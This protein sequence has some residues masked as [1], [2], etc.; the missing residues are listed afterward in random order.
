MNEELTKLNIRKLKT[1][2]EKVITECLLKGNCLGDI[3]EM[4]HRRDFDY[5]LFN[6]ELFHGMKLPTGTTIFN[7]Q[8]LA[9]GQEIVRLEESLKS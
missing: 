8:I 6:E 4:D 7:N 1:K 5:I 9:I 2:L 3:R